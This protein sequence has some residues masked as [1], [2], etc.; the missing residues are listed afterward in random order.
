VSAG[1]VARLVAT[2]F[3]T[4]ALVELPREDDAPA[5]AALAARLPPEERALADAFAPA[6]RL[7]FAGGRVALRAALAALGLPGASA[8]PILATPRGGPA[9]PAGVLGSIAHK[10][11]IAV[12]LAALVPA[13]APRDVTLGVDVEID[14]PSRFDIAPRVLTDGERARLAALPPAASARAVLAAFSA[15]EAVYKALDP[16]LGRYVSFDEV[17]LE[18]GTARLAPRAGE[19]SFR[20]E[21]AETPLDGHIL[22]TARVQ[23]SG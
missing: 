16:W 21:H 12:A 9:L 6:R 14:R 5:A 1:A 8:A 3:G 18:D 13:G 22:V 20:I 17:E 10:P 2:P 19:P 15:K 23:R 11:T 7:T 4:L